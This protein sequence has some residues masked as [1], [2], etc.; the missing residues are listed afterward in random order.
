MISR[1]SLFTRETAA[2][3]NGNLVAYDL[4]AEGDRLIVAQNATTATVPE[5]DASE[6]ERL[7]PRHQLLRGVEAGGAGVK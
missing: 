7:H 5:N 3:N 6:P 4:D 2:A 1:D